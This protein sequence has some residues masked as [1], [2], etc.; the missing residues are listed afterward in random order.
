MLVRVSGLGV[1]PYQND[2]P[3][4]SVDAGK[5]I[6]PK[7]SYIFPILRCANISYLFSLL[8]IV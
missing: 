7:Q 2:E 4:Q 8:H 5:I 1:Q 6:Q 3:V